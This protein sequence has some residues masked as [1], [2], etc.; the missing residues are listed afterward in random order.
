MRLTR[1][2]RPVFA[3]ALALPICAAV[4]AI[5]PEG[6]AAGQTPQNPAPKAQVAAPRVQA[7]LDQ[8]M[9]GIL[10]PNANVV[11]FAQE[12]DP[13]SVQ[14]VPKPSSATDPLAG[15]YGG[16]EAIENSSLAL[17]ESATLLTIPRVCS[18]GKMAPVKD[19]DWIKFVEGLRASGQAAYQ[20][21]QSK[22]MDK[23]LD[24]ADQVGTACLNCHDR[25]RQGTAQ[26]CT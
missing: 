9:R 11:F 22:N 16:W 13:A 25:Y 14:R 12:N 5:F 2:L 6:F 21:A 4:S 8:V 17:S 18:N 3:L 26:R 10:F 23:M 1:F 7:D 20:A 19:P 24:A 15:V